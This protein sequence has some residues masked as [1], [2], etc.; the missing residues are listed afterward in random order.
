MAEQ[1]SMQDITPSDKI[2]TW[3]ISET[4]VG[5]TPLMAALTSLPHSKEI[6]EKREKIKR[7]CPTLTSGLMWGRL[8]ASSLWDELSVLRNHRIN[9]VGS[10]S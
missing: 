3:Q 7:G 2:C 1:Q 8:I 10:G 9:L 4:G 5:A 6:V